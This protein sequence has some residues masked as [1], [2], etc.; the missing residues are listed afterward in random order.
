MTSWPLEYSLEV[1]GVLYLERSAI[2]ERCVMYGSDY[3]TCSLVS[4]GKEVWKVI[5]AE[6][7]IVVLQSSDTLVFL[8]RC[9]VHQCG[10]IRERLDTFAVF[11]PFGIPLFYFSCS[12]HT[13]SMY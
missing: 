12:C 4:Q 6:C 10:Q 11:L 7:G 2:V 3:L 9:F 1:R 13:T 5:F 8:R